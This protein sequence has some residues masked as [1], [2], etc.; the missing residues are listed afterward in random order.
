MVVGSFQHAESIR[1]YS[2]SS[3]CISPEPL[4]ILWSFRG[5][6]L[7]VQMGKVQ[8]SV[9][10]RDDGQLLLKP[11]FMFSCIICREG[12]VILKH[13]T[14]VSLVTCINMLRLVIILVG[15]YERTVFCLM[16]CCCSDCL[17]NIHNEVRISFKGFGTLVSTR[18]VLIHAFFRET[19]QKGVSISLIVP[20][21]TVLS[22]WFSLL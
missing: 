5:S 11:I 17:Y 8:N 12:A 6:E 14:N 20:V 7:L 2:V 15:R 16:C 21:A 4:E 13:I 19:P 18:T 22:K 1:V 3:V 10:P 9:R